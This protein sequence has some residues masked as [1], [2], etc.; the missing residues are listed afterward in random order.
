[1]QAFCLHPGLLAQF[2]V[3]N[4]FADYH[5]TVNSQS[6]Q[7]E[8]TEEELSSVIRRVCQGNTNEFRRIIDAYHQTVFQVVR[9]VVPGDDAEDVAQECFMRVYQALPKYREEGKFRAWIKHV[10]LNTAYDHWRK[11]RRRNEVNVSPDDLALLLRDEHTA[12]PNTQEQLEQRQLLK[13]AL[14][15]VSDEDRLLLILLYLEEWKSKD[16]AS[17]FGWSLAKTKVRAF[18]AKATVRRVLK[19]E[20]V[21][22]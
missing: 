12:E 9:I 14:G 6:R 2:S 8:P 21:E 13:R 4:P 11:K 22:K 1:M 15:S 16:V 7:M 3:R 18:R 20:Y 19:E 17:A 5:L 10:A